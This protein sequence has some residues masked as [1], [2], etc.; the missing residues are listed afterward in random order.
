MVPWGSRAEVNEWNTP[1]NG[2]KLVE[3]HGI[4]EREEKRHVVQ[5]SP[6]EEGT[7]QERCQPRQPPPVL[8][9]R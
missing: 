4:T 9:R 6:Q 3:V 1:A 8:N 5:A 2:W 7:S